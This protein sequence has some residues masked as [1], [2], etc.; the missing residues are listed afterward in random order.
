MVFVFGTHNICGGR[1]KYVVGISPLLCMIISPSHEVVYIKRPLSFFVSGGPLVLI[2]DVMRVESDSFWSLPLMDSHIELSLSR[3]VD[4]IL[5][6]SSS[7]FVEEYVLL[8]SVLRAL[9]VAVR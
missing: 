1:F 2:Y 4:N 6:T 8:C 9:G 3:W 5:I 7:L